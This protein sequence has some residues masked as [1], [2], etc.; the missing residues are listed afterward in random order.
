MKQNIIAMIFIILTTICLFFLLHFLYTK[1]KEGLKTTEN[2]C[3]AKGCPIARL[4]NDIYKLHTE[5]KAARD[6]NHLLS[7][8][9]G[10]IDY[11]FKSKG[12]SN[13]FIIRHGEKIKSKFALDCNGI[14]RSTYIPNLITSL[15]KKGFGIHNMITTNDY[16]SMHQQQTVMLTSWLYSIPLFIFGDSTESKEAVKNVFTNSYFNGKT[17]LF[18]WEHS[19][20]QELIKNI[21]SIGTKTKELNNYKFKNPKGTSGLPYWDTNNYKTIIHFDEKLNFKV[22]NENL[23]TCYEQ[24]NDVLIYGKKQK[25][26]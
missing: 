25:C 11:L 7:K 6:N 26:G 17:I 15:N 1:L 2:S 13:I 21:I 9:K 14:L 12:P 19:C 8:N 10:I 3:D 23:T 20:I 18:C 16:S 22:L 24:D 5:T 4:Q